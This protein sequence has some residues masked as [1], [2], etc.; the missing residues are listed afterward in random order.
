MAVYKTVPNQKVVK[1]KKAVCNGQ[2]IYA[3]INIAAMEKAAQALEAGAFKLWVYFAKNQNNYE[4]ALSSKD[5]LDTFGMKIKQYNS[6]VDKLIEAGY[7]V[8]EG[9]SNS[10]TFNENP[11]ITKEDNG[12]TTKK[13]VITF[14]DNAVIPKED[15]AVITFQDN[16]LLPLDIRNNTDNTQNNTKDNTDGVDKTASLR[17]AVIINS[18]ESQKIEGEITVH[19]LKSMGVKYEVIEGNKARII[20]TGKVFKLIGFDN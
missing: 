18:T 8:R 3:A 1:V 11:V 9:N 10:Y 4:F 7:L 5:V 6:A 16:P 17:S 2:N 20:D 12:E 15:N 14:Q 13:S 19:R